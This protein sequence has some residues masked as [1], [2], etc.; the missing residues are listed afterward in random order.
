[1]SMHEIEKATREKRTNRAITRNL[2][3]PSGKLGMI[4]RYLGSPIIH[5]G[6]SMMSS[7]SMDEYLGE[8]Y[9]VYD[10]PDPDK[11]PTFDERDSFIELEGYIFDGLSRGMH[12]EI[13][14][15]SE[16]HQLVVSYKGYPVYMEVAGDLYSYAPFPEWE[17]MI[18]RLYALAE[19]KFEAYKEVA[20]AQM[21]SEA[22]KR[23]KSFL[24]ELRLRWGI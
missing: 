22:T 24:Q 12:L 2:M 19:K 5:Q 15:K 3:G 20:S 14:Y 21:E 9:D 6:N 18:E 7:R 13:K 23:K 11:I 16:S 17:D 4:A 8:S 1:M 10:S